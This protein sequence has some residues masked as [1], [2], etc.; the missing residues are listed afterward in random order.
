MN[1][2]D[3]RRA[4]ASR[5]GGAT[6]KEVAQHVGVSVPTA[7]KMVDEYHKHRLAGTL[8][9]DLPDE[10]SDWYKAPIYANRTAG[11]TETPTNG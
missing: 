9:R 2:K 7:R 10:D 3:I 11:E 8:F 1:M 5:L 6:W 4:Q